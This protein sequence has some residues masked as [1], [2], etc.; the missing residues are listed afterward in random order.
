MTEKENPGVDDTGTGNNVN[1][2]AAVQP[3]AET[4]PQT[5]TPDNGWVPAGNQNVHQNVS[6]DLRGVQ[7]RQGGNGIAVA[8][9]VLALV[10]YPFALSIIFFP[11][12]FVC[13]VLGI[14]FSGVGLSKA[15]KREDRKH[16]GLS[17][18]GLAISFA[19]TGFVLLM[20]L[21]GMSVG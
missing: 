17:I 11:V 9:F 19:G 15:N 14:I 20:I 4:P 2:P 12:G 6:V 7:L 13:W 16:R 5:Q 3:P 18:A 10:A 21:A 8:G 1:P